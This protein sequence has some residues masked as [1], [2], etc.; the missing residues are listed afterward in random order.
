MKKNKK[1]LLLK[2]ENNM[3]NQKTDYNSKSGPDV[4]SNEKDPELLKNYEKLILALS[5]GKGIQAIADIGSE[6]LE[7]PISIA[8]SSFKIL[9]T[10]ATV[11]HFQELSPQQSAYTQAA[12]K[13]VS[14]RQLGLTSMDFIRKS[15]RLDQIYDNPEPHIVSR[16]ELSSKGIDTP[17]SFLDCSVR[18]RGAVVGNLTVLELVRPF[19]EGDL[20]YCKQLSRLISIEL[21]KQEIFSANYG[22]AYEVLLND[23]LEHK[24]TDSV[25]IRLRLKSMKR[26][27][28]PDLYVVVVRRID[29]GS[30]SADIPGIQQS[31]VRACFPGSISVNYRGDIVLLI[32]SEKEKAPEIQGNW[33][34]TEL[35][36]K[37][38][39]KLGKSEMFH[40]PAQMS[41]FYAQACRAIEYGG[42][43][44]P[45]QCIYDYYSFSL[46]HMM[47]ICS[48]K[49]DLRGLVHPLVQKLMKSGNLSDQELLK[50]LAVWL[51]LNR[52]AEKITKVLHI[53]RSTLYY[54]INKIRDMLGEEDLN[55]GK[56]VFQL[57]LSFR[58]IEYHAGL[59]GK[60]F[61]GFEKGL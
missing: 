29:P 42:I 23:L 10:S 27:L 31:V 20:D 17:F 61:R 53:H 33:E 3:E 2:K 22:V 30:G 38:N 58:V 36:E 18:I 60:P 48:E 51:Y 57:M 11:Q 49:M 44:D 24:V 6:Y 7:N 8:D 46:F 25:R 56:L 19:C 55:D 26:D 54:R 59:Q 34:L 52:D 35:L 4:A 39:L 37:N 45:G 28:K 12:L 43:Y 1:I 32:S 40:E 41:T 21:Q 16:E 47:E 14:D 50:T 13:S 5:E 15:G 9:A